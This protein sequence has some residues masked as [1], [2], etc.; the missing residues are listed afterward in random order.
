MCTKY[1]RAQVNLTNSIQLIYNPLFIVTASH[2]DLFL[3]LIVSLDRSH[4]F[5][6]QG[7]AFPEYIIREEFCF[8][9]LRDFIRE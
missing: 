1:M 8:F 3:V 7:E 6:G 2:P 9:S 5:L 4:K